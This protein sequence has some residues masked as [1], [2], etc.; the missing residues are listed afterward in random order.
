[1]DEQEKMEVFHAWRNAES[2]QLPMTEEGMKL[3]D[4]RYYGFCKG[5]A[6]AQFYAKHGHTDMKEHNERNDDESILNTNTT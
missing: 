6:Y 2:Y 5:W 3:A 4:A 1:M